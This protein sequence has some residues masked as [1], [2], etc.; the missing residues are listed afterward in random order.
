MRLALCLLVVCVAWPAAARDC[1]AFAFEN[2]RHAR[3]IEHSL[4]QI[5]LLQAR[6]SDLQAVNDAVFVTPG[7]AWRTTIQTSFGVDTATPVGARCRANVLLDTSASSIPLSLLA[8]VAYAP[9]NLRVDLLAIGRGDIFTAR[10]RDSDDDNGG[11]FQQHRGV[12]GAQIQLTRWVAL[13]VARVGT[14]TITPDA[15]ALAGAL[16]ALPE[17]PRW[18]YSAGIPALR[19]WTHL[20]DEGE[21]LALR[22]LVVRRLPVSEHWRIGAEWAALPTEDRQVVT[23]RVLYTTVPPQTDRYFPGIDLWGEIAFESDGALFR[24]V[25]VGLNGPMLRSNLTRKSWNK[26]GLD[27]E[28]R[29]MLSVHTGAQMR[30]VSDVGAAVGGQYMTALLM[31]TSFITMGFDFGFGFNVPEMLDLYPGMA[32]SI[33]LSAGMRLG[34]HW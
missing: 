8:G 33:T 3:I 34:N 30:Q 29:A 4:R 9:L 13:G 12:L 16:D 6:A 15:P 28:Q 32:N 24:Y 11:S 20:T 21:G 25:R 26:F 7:D 23:P 10:S 1:R 5:D 19:L 31:R 14:E 27:V 22:E 18:L 17:G 2:Q